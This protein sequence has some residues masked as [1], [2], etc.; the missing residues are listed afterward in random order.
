MRALAHRRG[1]IYFGG[2]V[3]GVEEVRGS[4]LLLSREL[5]ADSRSFGKQGNTSSD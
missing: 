2:V 5:R 4:H 3:A 1:S